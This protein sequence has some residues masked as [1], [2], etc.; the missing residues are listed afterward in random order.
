MAE[1]PEGD[2]FMWGPDLGLSLRARPVWPGRPV[3]CSG[4]DCSVAPVAPP[5]PARDFSLVRG[6]S[7][8]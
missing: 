8:A 3:H 5:P 1:N 6:C 4:A 7:G 2:R